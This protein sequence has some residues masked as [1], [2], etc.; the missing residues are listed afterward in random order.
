M[1]S[2]CPGV[3]HQSWSCNSAWG[4]FARLLNFTTSRWSCR[5][6]RKTNREFVD[7]CAFQVCVE[8]QDEAN[9]VMA[10]KG[11]RVNGCLLSAALLT[12]VNTTQ[13][14]RCGLTLHLLFA[15]ITHLNV[16]FL[17]IVPHR[18]HTQPL[19]RFCNQSHF[20]LSTWE[21]KN[22]L[23]FNCRSRERMK[24]IKI[25]GT[26]LH[27]RSRYSQLSCQCLCFVS[28][29]GQMKRSQDA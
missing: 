18:S 6:V 22:T 16:P 19:W 11:L 29:L 21:G 26:S 9:L 1:V 15:T 4:A 23:K 24:K 20:F 28:L 27:W 10:G 3:F 25:K 14:S 2:L 5:L 7:V 12:C 17:T 13:T 8:G